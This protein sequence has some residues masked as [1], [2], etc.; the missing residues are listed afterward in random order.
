MCDGDRH[1]AADSGSGRFPCID[2]P[3]GQTTWQRLG[4][5][6]PHR[7]PYE[8]PAVEDWTGD[9]YFRD[10]ES[11]D[12]IADS[13][14]EICSNPLNRSMRPDVAHF[15]PTDNFRER[16]QPGIS[17]LLAAPSIEG[18][19]AWRGGV[20]FPTT[21]IAA[22]AELAARSN[23]H[24]PE[25]ASLAFANT[26]AAIDV[27]SQNEADS[28]AG[29]DADH[30]EIV[31]HAAVPNPQAPAAFVYRGRRGIGFYD[32][33]DAVAEPLSIVMAQEVGDC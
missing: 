31:S 26:A 18:A 32:D 30:H 7:F 13:D 29:S 17:D 21:A 8:S 12:D 6:L 28:D 24:V 20:S 4:H 25:V 16:R 9:H 14:A 22:R 2:R 5:R 33:R 15:G 23:G 1:G 19:D 3:S 10:T 11:E 27:A